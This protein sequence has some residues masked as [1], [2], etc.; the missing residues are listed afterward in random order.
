MKIDDL[1][2]WDANNR[3]R[4][5]R[6]GYMEISPYVNPPWLRIDNPYCKHNYMTSLLQVWNEDVDDFVIKW[7]WNKSVGIVALSALMEVNRRTLTNRIKYLAA[8]RDLPL[9]NVLTRGGK[10]EMT[11][12]L[13]SECTKDLRDLETRWLSL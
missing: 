8:E 12:S 10:L 13:R 1:W 9:E 11:P 7:I 2:E 4:Y 6:A 5:D 3:P